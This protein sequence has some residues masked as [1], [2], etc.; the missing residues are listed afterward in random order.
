MTAGFASA[1]A[2]SATYPFDT[3]KI[4]MQTQ[5]HYSRKYRNVLQSVYRIGRE[6]GIGRRGLMRGIDASNARLFCY[7]SMKFG[8]YEPIKEALGAETK[9]STPMWVRLTA[10]A[11]SGAIATAVFNPFELLKVQM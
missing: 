10:G 11:T 5:P 6:E 9:E 1:M 2:G 8:L 7:C 4:R 3:A